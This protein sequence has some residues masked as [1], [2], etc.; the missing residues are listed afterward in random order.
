M[1]FNHQTLFYFIL[2]QLL[3]MTGIKLNEELIALG[4]TTETP[5]RPVRRTA[6]WMEHPKVY[7][8]FFA[9]VSWINEK[10]EIFLQDILNQPELKMITSYL[11][12]KYKSTRPSEADSS[13]ATGTLCI[14]KYK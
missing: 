12:E 3:G 14:A 13:F 1:F 10:G 11:N 9:K 5:A 8:R 6:S 4:F 7:K 2:F